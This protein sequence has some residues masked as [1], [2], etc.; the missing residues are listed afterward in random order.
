MTVVQSQGTLVTPDAGWHQGVTPRLQVPLFADEV[1][2]LAVIYR[3]QP[4]VRTVVDFLARNI[5]QIGLHVYRR[6]G[7]TNRVRLR[8]PDPVAATLE[9]PG[10]QLTAHRFKRDLI[11]DLAIYGNA[12]YAKVGRDEPGVDLLW[13]DPTRVIPA[14][15]RPLITTYTVVRSD[16]STV[17][18]PAAS[19]LHIR[20]ANPEDPRVGLSPLV[21]LQQILAEEWAANRYRQRLWRNGAR[22]DGV[23]TRPKDSPPWSD[24]ARKRFREEW[25]ALYGGESGYGRTAILEEGMGFTPTT[26]NAKDSQ[27]IEARKLTREEVAAAF[28]IPPPMV[29]VLDHATFSNIEQQH[30]M[31]YQDT[32]GPWLNLV[33]DEFEAQLLPDLTDDSSVYVEFNLAEKLKGSFEEQT[34]ALQSATGRPWMTADEAR[35]RQNLPSLGG[36]AAHLITPLNVATGAEA[37]IPQEVT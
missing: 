33:E 12:F 7:E 35:A 34:A 25:H 22:I 17:R 9:Q 11:T 20:L 4:S 28:H 21:S 18:L 37:P 23:V 6:V 15:P 10:P 8:R 27:Y 1:A 31:L 29:G 32:L 3:S 24:T 30:R 26:T 16:G 2:D 19:V 36:T 14:G 13:L 5:A